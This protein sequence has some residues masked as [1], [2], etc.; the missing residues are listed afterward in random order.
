MQDRKWGGP[1]LAKSQ[2]DRTGP[3]EPWETRECG[4]WRPG[5]QPEGVRPSPGRDGPGRAASPRG[6]GAGEP[7]RSRG[8]QRPRAP[9]AALSATPDSEALLQ[10][11]GAA[12]RE[13]EAALRR[14]SRSD[15]TVLIEGE[16]GS[17]KDRAAR[18]LHAWSPR[19]TGP[20]VEVDL[21]ALSPTLMEAELFGHEAGAYTGADRAR[22]GRFR[23]AQ[24][25][26]LL[27]GGVELCPESL[28][29]KLLRVLQ[30][31]QVEPLGSEASLP[32]DVRVVAT[33]SLDLAAQVRAGRFRGDLYYRLA[34]VVL[35]APPLRERLE[36]LPELV[37]ELTGRIARRSGV[38]AR[39]LS[40]GALERLARH[41][42]PG[43]LR[44][45]ENALERVLVLG[46]GGADR[47]PGRPIEAS[48]LEFLGEGVEG[49]AE[50]LAREVLAGGLT[51]ADLEQALIAEALR[52]HRGNASAAARKLGLTRR[53][54]EYR[55]RRGSPPQA[56]GAGEDDPGDEE[57]EGLGSGQDGAPR[58]GS[59]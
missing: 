2:P 59:R 56:S 19:A 26:T 48:E 58:R 14:V 27:L 57:R 44:E 22:L 9:H 55:R 42:W 52:A 53:A 32:V 18:L 41:A 46:S 17:G 8:A 5:S 30:E 20:L 47:D 24:G 1:H 50:R 33:S 28:Q 10:G 45:L 13:F 7:H 31:R 11:R 23:R 12:T 49:E 36:D 37:E 16:G 51:L 21:A 35:R 39:P 54:L 40:P 34:V 4:I 29:I 25:G 15:A 38:L 3:L 6:R 43:N